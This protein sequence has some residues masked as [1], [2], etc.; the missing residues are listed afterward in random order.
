M[1][2]LHL[3]GLRG[4]CPAV[5]AFKGGEFERTR[6][7]LKILHR[8]VT[9]DSFVGIRWWATGAVLTTCLVILMISLVVSIQISWP[10]L[11]TNRAIFVILYGGASMG[12][13]LYGVWFVK[14]RGAA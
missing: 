13:C 3:P 2:G 1:A 9:V 12:L 11:S 8:E 4:C 5:V 6:R 14:K 7:P 10:E